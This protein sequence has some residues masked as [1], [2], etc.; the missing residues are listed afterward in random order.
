MV[1]YIEELQIPGLTGYPGISSSASED[2]AIIAEKVPSTYMYLSAGF[3]DERGDYG[4][5]NPKVKF[6]E[7]VCPFGVACLVQCAMRWLNLS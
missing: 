1:S 3:D 4:A 5:H 6:N 2:F 7:D